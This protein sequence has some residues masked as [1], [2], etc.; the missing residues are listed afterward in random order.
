MP[1]QQIKCLNV[2]LECLAYKNLLLIKIQKRKATASK[3][4][5]MSLPMGIKCQKNRN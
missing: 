2:L 4:A 3:F 5:E 1:K